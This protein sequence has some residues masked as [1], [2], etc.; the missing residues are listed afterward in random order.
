[1]VSK[2]FTRPVRK[3]TIRIWED[4]YRL[5][6]ELANYNETLRNQID[7]FCRGLER[8]M[9]EAAELDPDHPDAKE[10]RRIL[11]RVDEYRREHGHY[12]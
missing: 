3:I 1:M 8:E 11:A 5:L 12:G 6:K 7:E 10:A 9:A 4:N 2:K